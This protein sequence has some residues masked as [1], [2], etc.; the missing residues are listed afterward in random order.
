MHTAACCG[1][2]LKRAAPERAIDVAGAEHDPVAMRYCKLLAC[3]NPRHAA[4]AAARGAKAGGS[5]GAGER[6]GRQRVW[7]QAGCAGVR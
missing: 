3:H 2:D 7:V 4:A 1:R 5:P 6:P